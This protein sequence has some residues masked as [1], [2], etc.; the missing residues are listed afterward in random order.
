MKQYIYVL[1]LALIFSSCSSDDTSD[2][3]NTNPSSFS[4]NTTDLRFN[5]AT[6][7][8]TEAIDPDGDNVTYAIILDGQEIASGGTVLTYSFSGLESETSYE[9]YVEARD[10]NGGTSRADFFFT[11]TPEV[12]VYDIGLSLR[13]WTAPFDPTKSVVYLHFEI[14]G[15]PDAVSYHVEVLDHNPDTN[16]SNIG[17]EYM[18][19]PNDDLPQG[20]DGASEFNIAEI[21]PNVYNIY[22]LGGTLP[23]TNLQDL[24]DNLSTYTGTARVTVTYGN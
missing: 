6:I 5:G 20:N 7:E 17:R 11:T 3:N 2:P 16:P 13:W 19:T 24:I 12:F 10:G 1:V 15:D 22:T 23:N 18:W 21:S 8:W 14:E 4:A 9:G